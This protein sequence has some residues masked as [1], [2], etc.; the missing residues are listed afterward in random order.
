MVARKQRQ[1]K[2]QLKSK[3][4]I[5]LGG[6]SPLQYVRQRLQE[7]TTGPTPVDTSNPK[8][9]STDPTDTHGSHVPAN[10]AGQSPDG[11]LPL[12]MD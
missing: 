10:P 5:N 4:R 11:M 2:H 9:H 1:R 8:N 3:Q 6:L 12:F 7:P